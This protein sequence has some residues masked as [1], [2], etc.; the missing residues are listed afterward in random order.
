MFK[1]FFLILFAIGWALAAASLH[2]IRTPSNFLTVS[3][4]PKNELTFDDTYV[5]TR[6]WT[7]DDVPHHR[8]LVVRLLATGKTDV[9]AH[10]ADAHS[11]RDIPTQ[12][13]NALGEAPAPTPSSLPSFNAALSQLKAGRFRPEDL[14]KIV[15]TAR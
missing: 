5:D 4:L 9:I 12:L 8:D 3:F 10:I 2:I 1:F 11:S 13:A 15:A 14:A 6:L 7:I